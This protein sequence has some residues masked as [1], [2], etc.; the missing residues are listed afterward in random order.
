MKALFFQRLVLVCF[1]V[2]CLLTWSLV[3]AA[4]EQEES[5]TISV[6]QTL[7]SEGKFTV[8]ALRA[9]NQLPDRFMT[10]AFELRSLDI[11]L[12]SADARK[13]RELAMKADGNEQLR[14][15]T[16]DLQALAEHM[17]EYGPQEPDTG[18]TGQQDTLHSAATW[19][20]AEAKDATHRLQSMQQVRLQMPPV[21]TTPFL[22]IESITQKQWD[23]AVTAAQQ[24]VGMLYGRLSPQEQ[25]QFDADWAPMHGYPTAECVD[26]LNNLNPLLAEFLA[27][28]TA[29]NRTSGQLEQAMIEAGWAAQLDAETLTRQYLALAARYRN[30]LYS[31]QNRMDV[32]A[33]DIASLGDPPDVR[34]LMAR[35]QKRYHSAKEYIR[36][37]ISAMDKPAQT[38]EGVWVGY[39]QHIRKE[40][41]MAFVAT[42]PYNSDPSGTK[43]PSYR[44]IALNIS[45]SSSKPKPALRE[46]FG[47]AKSLDSGL[48]KQKY[49]NSPSQTVY[50]VPSEKGNL[51]FYYAEKQQDPDLSEN[52]P[53]NLQIYEETANK[54]ISKLKKEIFKM[55]ERARKDYLKYHDGILESTNTLEINRIKKRLEKIRHFFRMQPIF[56]S[57]AHQWLSKKPMARA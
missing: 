23:G 38:L 34:T 16:D 24:A 32:V 55:N 1:S 29:I 45:T 50:K 42:T 27:L 14:P 39:K 56:V 9:W 13:V 11:D 33:R 57:T 26:Y 28:R 54:K 4:P 49:F 41:P 22:E 2:T 31:M 35:A 18:S 3:W 30:F 20:E 43:D 51:H 52:G 5:E 44:I 21:Q 36:S 17:A 7:E 6:L 37:A 25:K 48:L 53:T 10:L 8:R 40:E 12:M 46:T 15:L 47:L 19:Q